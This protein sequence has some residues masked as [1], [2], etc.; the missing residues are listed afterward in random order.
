[1]TVPHEALEARA[2]AS[3][4]DS[5]LLELLVGVATLMIGVGFLTNLVPLAAC[6]GLLWLLWA[7]MNARIVEPRVGSAVFGRQ[8]RRREHR[9]LRVL[10]AVVITLLAGAAIAIAV[11][12]SV[13]SDL[14][15]GLPVA[16]LALG[17][18]A[19]ATAFGLRRLWVHAGVFA[20]GAA[21]TVALA[22]HPG[23]GLLAAGGTLA[24]AGIVV[25]S[26]FLRRHPRVDVDA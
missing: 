25:L 1:M 24:T 23:W 19:A 5:G 14:V 16:L 8:R 18:A 6:A 15:D 20:V 26:R 2:Y 21:L 12:G 11:S 22:W 10:L 4:F 7:P 17:A 9:G 13:P 3:R